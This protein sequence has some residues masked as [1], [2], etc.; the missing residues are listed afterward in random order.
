MIVVP[1]VVVPVIVVSVLVMAVVVVP[2]LAV[3]VIAVVAAL[4]NQLHLGALELAARRRSEDEQR[5]SLGEL[6]LGG[7]DGS[8]VLG[9]GRRVLEAH[10]VRPRRLELHQHHL[11]FD[12]DVE[13]AL[14]MHMCAEGAR[15]PRTGPS[16]GGEEQ[17]G[18]GKGRDSG[19]HEN[20]LYDNVGARYRPT[21]PVTR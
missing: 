6:G 5:A 2:M 14:A 8:L 19:L 3:A 18:E 17:R 11:A 9:A 15:L 12:G 10:D 4:G 20:L 1:V 16:G 21:S 13:G 7:L